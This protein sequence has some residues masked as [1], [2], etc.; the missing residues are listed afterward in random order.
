M[1]SGLVWS[2]C[3]VLSSSALD[4]SFISR[5]ECGCVLCELSSFSGSEL[6]SKLSE[7]IACVVDLSS[8]PPSSD[9]SDCYSSSPPILPYDFWMKISS[10]CSIIGY[11]PYVNYYWL[12]SSS[13]SESYSCISW[14]VRS[15]SAAS[16]M[17]SWSE[18]NWSILDDGIFVIKGSCGLMP[19]LALCGVR[20][21]FVLETSLS[22]LIVLLL[23]MRFNCLLQI[24]YCLINIMFI[25]CRS[26][27]RNFLSDSYYAQC[28]SSKS[29]PRLYS[30]R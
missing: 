4:A 22:S 12:A 3:T 15:S 25:F 6:L 1:L 26:S 18:S 10:A 16:M 23:P 9:V 5:W 8:L 20:S 28:W 30:S 14:S 2:S 19:A 11:C 13:L 29:W 24:V 21:V 17:L 27:S 7:R